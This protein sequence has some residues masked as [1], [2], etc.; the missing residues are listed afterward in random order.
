MKSKSHDVYIAIESFS[1]EVAGEQ[2]QIHRGRTK[3][4]G[5]DAVFKMN[6]QY[7]EPLIEQATAA[8]GE[9]RG[10]R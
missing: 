2:R 5:D 10:E 4:R 6:P 8:P 7:F 9:R 3:V 1:C